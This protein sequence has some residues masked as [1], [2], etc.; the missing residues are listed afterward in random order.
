MK[1]EDFLDIIKT[2]GL[3]PILTQSDPEVACQLVDAAVAAGVNIFEV[4]N[5]TANAPAVFSALKNYVD[6]NYPHVLLGVGTL[7]DVE[8]LRVFEEAGADFFVAPILSPSVGAYAKEK[9]LLWIPGCGTVTEVYEADIFGATLIKLYPANVLGT[10]F[11]KSIHAVMP[12]VLLMPTGGVVPEQTNLKNWFE[13][14]AFCVGM[15]SQ[16]FDKTAIEK[17]DFKKISKQIK[18]IL[19]IIKNCR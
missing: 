10:A 12:N 8:Q 13:S 4:T 1:K 18:A 6:Q 11:L 16:L 2:D 9:E 15:G 5:R 3:L 19:E 14:G 17:R 7:M